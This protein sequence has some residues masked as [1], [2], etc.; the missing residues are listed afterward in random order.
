MVESGIV[1][2]KYWLEVGPDEQTRRLKS[3]IHDGRKTWKLSD[4]DLKSYSRWYDYSRARDTM[5]AA[6]DSD[7]APWHIAHSDDKK[8]ARLNIIAHLLSQI[9]TSHSNRTM[10]GCPGANHGAIT[11]NRITQPN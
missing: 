9:P 10:S 5:L 4:L 7:W 8:R 2:L 1:L 11:P 3:R 6:T